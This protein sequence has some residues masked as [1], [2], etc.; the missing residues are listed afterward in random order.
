MRRLGTLLVA[1]PLVLILLAVFVVPAQAGCYDRHGVWQRRCP[2]PVM[3]GPCDVR[4]PKPE[5]CDED[6]SGTRTES[7]RTRPRIRPSTASIS[8]AAYRSVGAE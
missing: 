7:G 4:E 2:P 8:S 5:R 1:I 6:D 3:R